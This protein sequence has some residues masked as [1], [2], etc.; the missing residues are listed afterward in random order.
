M[1][2]A[3]LSCA[4]LPRCAID[5][6]AACSCIGSSTW[7]FVGDSV[8]RGV[9]SRLGQWL[10]EADGVDIHRD[11]QIAL[12]QRAKVGD[13]E[14]SGVDLQSFISRFSHYWT[15]SKVLEDWYTARGVLATNASAKKTFGVCGG[16]GDPSC[17]SY[18]W[19]ACGGRVRL[20]FKQLTKTRELNA[21]KLQS[22]LSNLAARGH[23]VDV[24]VLGFGLHDLEPAYGEASTDA[25]HLA[26]LRKSFLAVLHGIQG[27]KKAPSAHS[28][29][30]LLWLAYH[31]R[32]E[33]RAPP[34]FRHVAAGAQSNRAL[35]RMNNAARQAARRQAVPF[36]DPSCVTE[37]FATLDV[38][39]S[40]TFDGLHFDRETDW[41]KAQLVLARACGRDA[42]R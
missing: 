34:A 7:L 21:G 15:K 10:L 39:T 35:R 11:S 27:T 19:K 40:A 18:V 31:P 30:K 5:A 41:K 38:N 2:C 3:A 1:S 14:L 22:L 4:A 36:I 9:W 32:I 23:R 26:L 6:P 16:L 12:L 37:R 24:L 17:P 42:I 29:R 28:P 25:R 13:G 8:I 33:S 20:V